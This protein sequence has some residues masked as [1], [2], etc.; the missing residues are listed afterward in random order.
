[1]LLSRGNQ[2]GIILFVALV[3]S[4]PAL[5]LSVSLSKISAVDA[6]LRKLRSA[7]LSSDGASVLRITEELRS[8]FMET[9]DVKSN[10]RLLAKA[11]QSPETLASPNQC[12]FDDHLFSLTP[13]AKTELQSELQQTRLREAVA[14]VRRGG[15]WDCGTENTECKCAGD[16]RMVDIDRNQWAGST[17]VDVEVLGGTVKCDGTTFGVQRPAQPPKW[18]SAAA[19]QCECKPHKMGEVFDGFHLE[20]RLSS[21]S[22]LQEAW[23]FL[24]RLL[25]RT[26]QMP[27]G[28][29]DKTYHGMENWSTRG[30]AHADSF[31]NSVVLERFWLVKYMRE[32]A[33]YVVKG[34]RC[35]EW[36]NP[37]KPG[38][39]LMYSALIP[40][41]TMQYDMQFDHIYWNGG[42]KHVSGNVVHS[43]IMSLPDVLAA[44]GLAM[45][46]IFATQV[47]EHLPD[48]F[49][50]AQALFRATAPGG[51]VIVTAPQ[52]AQF[53]QVPHDYFRYTKEG[54]KYMLIKAGF[55]VPNQFF[56]GGG[57]FVFDVARS[58]GLQVQ[59]FALDEVE[60]GWQV[61]YDL[62]SDSAITI[63]ALAI[64]PPHQWCQNSTAGWDELYRRGIGAA[65]AAAAAAAA[66]A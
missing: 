44:H 16:A 25:S 24:L 26:A 10:A 48:P 39:E 41:C 34:P 19:A 43:D 33:W 65:S 66:A 42:V 47:F 46:A 52:Q 17:V 28:T 2:R 56:A 62:V 12:I 8:P 54:L 29:G 61:G 60:A 51:V 64:K 38:Q 30:K 35:L 58:A 27:L 11:K 5:T 13:A 3:A 22:R 21:I 50:A 49:P 59:D 9:K 53:H 18:P 1:M 63:H 31:G 23:I 32:V 36:G 57:D 4:S 14:W 40:G 15:W 55:C 20:K 37:A 6:A 45:D 7:L